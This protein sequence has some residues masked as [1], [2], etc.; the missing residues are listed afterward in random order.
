MRRSKRDA[1]SLKTLLEFRSRYYPQNDE[2]EVFLLRRLVPSRPCTD[3]RIC[4]QTKAEKLMPAFLTMSWPSVY[5]RDLPW[6]PLRGHP[7]TQI[8]AGQ[9]IFEQYLFSLDINFQCLKSNCLWNRVLLQALA[10]GQSAGEREGERVRGRS[11]PTWA[12]YTQGL[13]LVVSAKRRC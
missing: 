9:R 2:S 13:E 11:W 12:M 7:M 8:L 3:R 1:K 4:F 10:F 5:T 6:I